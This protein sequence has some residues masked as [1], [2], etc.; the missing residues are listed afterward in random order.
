MPQNNIK[1]IKEK[2]SGHLGQIVFV[3]GIIG[4]LLLF[5]SS[6]LGGEKGSAKEIAATSS[7]ATEQYVQNMEKELEDI[8]YKLLGDKNVSVMITL[9]SGMQYIYAGETKTDTGL[10]EDKNGSDSLKKEQSDTNEQSYIIVKDSDGN[11]QPLL[12]TEVMPQV[13]GVVVICS[14]GDDKNVQKAVQDAVVTVLDISEN[15][16][17]VIGRQSK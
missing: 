8:V 16:V 12:I 13:K 17:C 10:T 7:D 15:K 14:G 4:I 2:F 9:K 1:D 6:F 3:A 11:E 5:L